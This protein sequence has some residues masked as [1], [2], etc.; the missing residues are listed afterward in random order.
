LVANHAGFRKDGPST[1]QESHM[2]ENSESANAGV[3]GSPTPD[4]GQD[5]QATSD[6]FV[7]YASKDAATANAVV[8]V[9]ESQGVKCWIAPR[10]VIP[11]SQ[12]ADGIVRA[13]N[14]AKL[15]VVVL[16]ESAIASPHVGKEI[17]RAS[18]KQRPI[19]ALKTDA[20]PLTPALEYFL[21]ESQWVEV[22]AESTEAA[23]A[24]LSDAVRRHLSA[25]PASATAAPGRPPLIRAPPK[26]RTPWIAAA[27]V[28][29]GALT[30]AYFVVDKFWLSKQAASGRTAAGA[31]AAAAISDK[32]VAVLP[33]VDMSERKDQAYFSDGLAEELIDMLARVPDL[34]VP[35]R[36]SSFYFKE[37]HATIAE[38][39][40]ALSVAHILEGSVRR[41]GNTVRVTVQLIRADNGYHLWSETYDRDLQDVF[42]V[43][44]DISRTVVEKLKLTLGNAVPSTPPRTVN[45]EVHNLYLQGRYF[46]QNES[47]GDLEKAIGSF[48]RAIAIDP[49]YAPAWG[50]LGFAYFRQVANGYVEVS[51]GDQRVTD[52]AQKAIELDPMLSEPYQLL[53]L[54]K[55]TDSHDWAGA[56][57]ALDKALQVD[58]TNIGALINDAH[59]TRTVGNIDDALAKFSQSLDRDPLDLLNRRYFARVLYFAGR[60]DEA[61]ATIRQVLEMSPSFPAAHYELGRILLAKGQVAAAVSEFEAEKS[62]GWREFGLPLGYHAQQRT[63]DANAA[64]AVLLANSAGSEFQVAE[65]YAYFGNSDKAFYWLDRAIDHDPGIQW[66]RGDPL[67][68]GITADPRY[69]ALLRKLNLPP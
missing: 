66:L 42:K 5:A 26:R 17:E 2:Q 36:T 41:S 57:A 25:P 18:S 4:A 33:F 1:G 63:S 35:A 11:G 44:D 59:L 20:T 29:A 46:L 45:P 8:A 51:Q 37:Q 19:I 40:K 61:E 48:R 60:L 24:K 23:L 27:V 54:V 10:N 47:A 13:I 30:L 31:P 14:G 9:L 21:S 68:K 39:A 53:S 56:R 69:A 15:V 64:L 22:G 58:P 49:T 3:L 12:Y 28:C 65:T 38:I 34:R 55:M 50:L 43:Q 6:V 52:A 7:S 16:S 32:S 67:F 62:P